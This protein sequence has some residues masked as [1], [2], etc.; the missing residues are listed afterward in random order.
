MLLIPRIHL[1]SR[2]NLRG[3][4]NQVDIGSMH[5]DSDNKGR[6]NLELESE[7]IPISFKPPGLEMKHSHVCLNL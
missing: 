6:V 7:L 5:S 3:I 1:E 4:S 2:F